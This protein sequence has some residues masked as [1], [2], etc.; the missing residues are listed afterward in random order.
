MVLDFIAFSIDDV[1]LGRITPGNG[2]FWQ[3]G[4]FNSNPNI[5]N[6]WRYGTKM[7]PFDEKVHN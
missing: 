6:P 1:Q 5:L 4:G 2:G 3:H 7:A